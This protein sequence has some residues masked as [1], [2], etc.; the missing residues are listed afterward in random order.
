LP[1]EETLELSIR[2]V[3]RFVVSQDP[4]GIAKATMVLYKLL[5]ERKRRGET[6]NDE[7]T[8]EAMLEALM[9]D[10]REDKPPDSET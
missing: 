5:S 8:P 10:P 1:D 3:F 2:Q 9:R 7:T 6:I 4:R